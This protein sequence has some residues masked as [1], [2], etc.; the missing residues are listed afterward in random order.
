ME[1]VSCV[2]EK[3]VADQLPDVAVM[4]YIP[5]RETEPQAEPGFS[6]KLKQEG[7]RAGNDQDP[8]NV[9]PSGETDTRV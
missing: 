7:D 3:D 1:D 9:R 4:R 2:V 5:R 6:E 8:D